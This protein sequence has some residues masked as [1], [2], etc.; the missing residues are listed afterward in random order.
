LVELSVTRKR[1]DA[2]P[3]L[4]AD[5]LAVLFC[6]I[7]PGLLAASTGFHFASKTNR[8]WR[9]VHLAG[10]TP[11]EIL[12]QDDRRILDYGCG[13]TTFIR[14]PTAQADELS[15]DEFADAATSFERRIA[16]H[17]PRFLAFLGKAAISALTGRRDLTWGMQPGKISESVVW[18]LPN[19][20]GRNRAF[21][22]DQLVEAYRP[23]HFAVMA[24]NPPT[25]VPS[26]AG[27]PLQASSP[28][29]VGSN[30]DTVG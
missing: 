25:P 2:L 23:L 21:T 28:A 22:L 3:D 13:L 17:R 27:I 26:I 14:R 30:S 5:D 9:T 11:Q 19:P 24:A 29:I 16:R 18:V 12:P 7:N 6:G 1:T 20:S 8:F 10:F 4:I 15:R